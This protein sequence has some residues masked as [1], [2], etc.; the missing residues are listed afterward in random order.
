MIRAAITRLLLSALNSRFLNHSP[1][2]YGYIGN[3]DAFSIE[4]LRC[5]ERQR[6]GITVSQIVKEAEMFKACPI[7]P[8]GLTVIE[9]GEF[10][11]AASQDLRDLREALNRER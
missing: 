11:A 6:P 7:E 2:Q 4:N 10:R 8:R 5:E 9:E 3:V 1:C